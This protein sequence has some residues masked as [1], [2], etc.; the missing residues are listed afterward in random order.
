MHRYDYVSQPF[1]RK[2][3][4]LLKASVLHLFALRL[5]RQSHIDLLN[6]P[7]ANKIAGF[8]CLA[9]CS[10]TALGDIEGPFCVKARWNVSVI[11]PL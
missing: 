5:A 6:Q 2:L 7:L 4:K 10:F 1:Q 8:S 3:I 11:D 9:R